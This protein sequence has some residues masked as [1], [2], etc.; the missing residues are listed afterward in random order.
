MLLSIILTISMFPL[1]CP[2]NS[3]KEKTILITSWKSI[4]LETQNILMLEDKEPSHHRKTIQIL[5]P[6]KCHQ[7]ITIE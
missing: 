1:V 4:L 5:A 6:V 3:K 7:K 2:Q